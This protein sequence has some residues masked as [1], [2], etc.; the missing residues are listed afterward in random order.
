MKRLLVCLWLVSTVV[1][2]DTANHAKIIKEAQQQRIA[3]LQSKRKV[4]RGRDNFRRID[5]ELNELKKGK[6]AF[7]K[8]E[9]A[10]LKIGQ[11]G[12]VT[13][14]LEVLNVVNEDTVLLM[15][16]KSGG[17]Y[18]VSRPISGLSAVSA[19]PNVPVMI[20]GI[21]TAGLTD[22]KPFTSSQVLLVTGTQQYNNTLG[23]VRTVFV[24]EAI[25]VGELEPHFKGNK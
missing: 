24:L 18:S 21:S 14:R 4:T 13:E 19:L 9:C 10:A 2:A 8:L 23:S 16:F 17:S 11:V 3:E 20:K 25:N 6:V 7:Q 1:Y 5:K 15:S 22:G 12:Y